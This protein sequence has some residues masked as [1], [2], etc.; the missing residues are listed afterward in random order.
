[1]AFAWMSF[2]NPQMMLL[3]EPESHLDI[4]TID[5]LA[6][7]LTEYPGAVV[8]VSHDE[9]LVS[10]VCNEMWIVHQGQV[11]VWDKD[12]AAYKKVLQAE[13]NDMTLQ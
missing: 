6:V 5:A 9:R 4:E 13:L 8:I 12:W 7:A 10:L 2:T 11:Q 3:D 1:M